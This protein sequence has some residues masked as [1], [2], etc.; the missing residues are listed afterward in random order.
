MPTTDVS[1]RTLD[2][3]HLAGT[4]VTPEQP[5]S[6]AVVLVHGGGV[7]REEGGFF[8]RLAAGLAEAGVASLRFDLRGHGQSEGRQ[9]ELTLSS[10][11]NDIRATLTY[12]REATGASELSLL[13]T[14][15]TGGVCAYYAAKQSQE[16]TRLVLFNP[17]LNYK[18]RTIDNRPFWVDDHLT[19]EAAAQLTAQGY[20]SHSPTLKHGR[21]IYNEVFW[22]RP[23]EAL[24]EVQAPTLIVHGTK[25][26]FV[27]IEASRA[28]VPLFQA[29]CRLVEIEG[30]QH[31][32]A[33]HDDPQY[34]DPQS[35][36]WQAF[37]IRT[38]ADWLVEP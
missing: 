36:E 5:T 3:L 17:Q 38:T 37:V 22:L 2:G 25:D 27:P 4:L 13:G 1:V 33:V 28:A 35:Q 23:H 30:A 19:D 26:T 16:I 6:R 14:S 20:L 24:G 9:E 8:T 11:L 15:F 10:I 29:P 21:A 34:L 18:R 7:T 31:G 32:F 12:L